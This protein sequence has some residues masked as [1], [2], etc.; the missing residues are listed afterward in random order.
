MPTSERIVT[1]A[2]WRPYGDGVETVW[3]NP[4]PWLL[5][6]VPVMLAM[7]L[8]AQHGSSEW[9]SQVQ[10]P[11]MRRS[12]NELVRAYPSSWEAITLRSG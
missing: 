7:P 6:A 2:K 12:Q 3:T 8:L 9:P 11:Q 4:L 1:R 10:L 5:V